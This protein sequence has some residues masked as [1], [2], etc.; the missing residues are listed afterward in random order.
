MTEQDGRGP[1]QEESESVVHLSLGQ[2]SHYRTVPGVEGSP[3]V[4]SQG[5][6]FKGF[7]A[8]LEG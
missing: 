3:Q 7:R 8:G 1:I 2:R 4:I 6:A 5:Q